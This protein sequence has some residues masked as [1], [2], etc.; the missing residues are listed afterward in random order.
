M[1]TRRGLLHRLLL[2]FGFEPVPRWNRTGRL[3]DVAAQS[4]HA[5]TR[6]P[7]SPLAR[8][9][10][11]DLV[12]FGEILAAGAPVGPHARDLL[13]EHIAHQVARRPSE[14]LVPYRTTVRLLE[15]L[16]GAR[17][18]TLAPL[19]RSALVTRF[20][21]GS[22]ATLPDEDLGPFPDDASLVRTRV[23]PDLIAGYYA[24]PAGWAVVG[25][26]VFPGR[27]GDLARY[28]GPGA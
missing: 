4:V 7:A 8:S 9:E 21:L 27:C 12:A 19:E 14:V 26:D 6:A 28:T 23:V 16:G 5:D 11:D 22:A 10:V 18:A 20:R 2:V 24:S 25:Y 17:F 3:A 1:L 15:R 13:A